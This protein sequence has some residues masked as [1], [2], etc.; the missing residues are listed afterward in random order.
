[1]TLLEL[2]KKTKIAFL[3]FVSFWL[4]ILLIIF[5]FVKNERKKAR[6]KEELFNI[7]T[8]NCYD[9]YDAGRPF[10]IIGIGEGLGYCDN[11]KKKM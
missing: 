11:C 1:M 6:E 5:V 10:G 9:L 8:G 4:I 2:W 7:C 3:L